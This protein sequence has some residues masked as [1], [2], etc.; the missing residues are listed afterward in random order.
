MGVGQK[1]SRVVLQ[2]ET[3]MLQRVW[4]ARRRCTEFL[5]NVM[6]M[7]DKRMIKL[8][9]LEARESQSKVKW[10]EDLKCSLEKFGWTN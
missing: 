6:R 10:L 4:E 2:C 9:A 7:E 1:H 8:V 3:M 5:L